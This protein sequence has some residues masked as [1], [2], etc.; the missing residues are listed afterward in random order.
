M[1]IAGTVRADT[2]GVTLAK[3]RTGTPPEGLLHPLVGSVEDLGEA[4]VHPLPSCVP[5]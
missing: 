2:G 5:Q 1:G 4:A 3:A